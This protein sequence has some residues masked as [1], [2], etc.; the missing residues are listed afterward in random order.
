MVGISSTETS[1]FTAANT[2]PCPLTVAMTPPIIGGVTQGG[3]TVAAG[4]NPVLVAKYAIVTITIGVAIYGMN[5]IGFNTIA[6]QML[7]VR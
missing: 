5:K 3:I 7:M 1:K 6:S 2:P 4:T